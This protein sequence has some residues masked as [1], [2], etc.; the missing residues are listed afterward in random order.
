MDN[1]LIYKKKDLE[2]NGEVQTHYYVNHIDFP[3][4]FFNAY[5]IGSIVNLYPDITTESHSHSF[6]TLIWF[7]N[8]S[9]IHT[10]DFDRFQIEPN[11]IFFIAPMQLHQFENV[12]NASGYTITFS[13]EFLLHL[14]P[15]ILQHIKYSL[16]C[17]PINKMQKLSGSSAILENIIKAIIGRIN[18]DKLFPNNV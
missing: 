2:V 18:S 14:D 17:N 15:F 11:S 13:E 5:T 16:F 4:S 7:K 3:N 10:I 8:G 9:G 6:Y 1:S 12:N